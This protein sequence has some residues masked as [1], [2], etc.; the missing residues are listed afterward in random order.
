MDTNADG[1]L[2]CIETYNWD[3]EVFIASA[4]DLMTY[5]HPKR[6]STPKSGSEYCTILG[7]NWAS[8]LRNNVLVIEDEDGRI[9]ADEFD[10]EIGNLMEEEKA[11]LMNDIYNHPILFKEG[12]Y[13]F[14]IRQS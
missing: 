5:L 14:L 11:Q 3:E 8:K 10:E 7:T 6:L 4:I 13:T 9:S 1:Y 2:S 12:K